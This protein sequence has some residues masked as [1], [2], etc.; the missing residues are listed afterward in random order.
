MARL[1]PK[2]LALALLA[3]AGLMGLVQD[4]K[5]QTL[6][7]DSL[8]ANYLEGFMD[9]VRWDGKIES[10]TATIGVIGS[11]DLV[12]HLQQVAQRKAKGRQLVI[13][14]LKPN[15][16]IQGLNILFVGRGNRANWPAL[17]KTCQNERILLV[18]DENDF[19]KAGGCIEFVLQRNRL[20]F[21][22]DTDNAKRCGIE[23][24]S[25][26]VEITVE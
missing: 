12:T 11:Q 20:R 25:K 1:H 15:D 4:G 13:L 24:S 7:I 22:V 16:P 19:L 10:E 5:A 18:G 2:L 23:V 6:Q 9:F 26:L 17:V 14:R 3:F 8:K 21:R